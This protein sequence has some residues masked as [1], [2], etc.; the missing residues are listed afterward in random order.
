[1]TDAVRPVWKCKNCNEEVSDI[2]IGNIKWNIAQLYCFLS[3]AILK[4]SN[5]LEVCSHLVERSRLH[6][7]DDSTLGIMELIRLEIA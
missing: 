6:V 7:C 4:P 2:W 1:M 3:A 5:Q